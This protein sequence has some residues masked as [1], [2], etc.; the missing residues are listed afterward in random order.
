MKEVT[1]MSAW[2]TLEYLH[3]GVSHVHSGTNCQDSVR[4]YE[5]EKYIIASLADGL[6]SLQYSEIAAQTATET[7]CNVLAGLKDPF[8]EFNK[9]SEF[10]RYILDA[11]VGNV[12]KKASELNVPLQQMDCTL[13]FVCVLKKQNC[14]ILGRLGDSAICVIADQ[15]SKAINDGNKSANGTNA[16]LDSDAIDHFEIEIMDLDKENILGFIL[17]SDG[18]ENELYMKGSD[19][20]NK[21]AELY[22]NAWYNSDNPEAFIEE[23]IRKI[24]G[25]EE[26]PFDDDIS[27]AVLNRSDAKINLPEDP[28]W[29]CSCGYRNNLQTTYCLKCHRD[30]SVLY[31]NIRFRDY[32]GKAAFF[33]RINR[34]PEEEKRIVGIKE[35]PK[36]FVWQKNNPNNTRSQ[37]SNESAQLDEQ[38]SHESN[39]KNIS[40]N[41]RNESVSNQSLVKSSRPATRGYVSQTDVKLINQDE[42]NDVGAKFPSGKTPNVK[43]NSSSM[44]D[45]DQ[46]AHKKNRAN[47]ETGESNN[48]KSPKRKSGYNLKLLK[49]VGILMSITLIL[50][51]VI[52]VG[53]SKKISSAKIEKLTDTVQQYEEE[54]KNRETAKQ[55][56]PPDDFS[57]L[58]EGD[59]YWG[60]LDDS[61]IPNGFGILLHENT[62]YIGNH[63]HGKKNGK[64][65]V[66]NGYGEQNIENYMNGNLITDT[67]DD[68]YSSSNSE[69]NDYSEDKRTTEWDEENDE[70]FTPLL[71]NSQEYE[72]KY[73]ANMRQK[74]GK[75]NELIATLSI[76]TVVY[77][78]ETT[79]KIVDNSSWAHVRTEDGNEGWILTESIFN[80]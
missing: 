18:L 41:T 46:S 2:K 6:G 37:G 42:S 63:V 25:I 23:R 16:I 28:K 52:G 44:E 10:A 67:Q 4:T 39:E 29:L 45:S 69:S 17:S 7:T 72:L 40:E 57:I 49:T 43:K 62:Y 80:Q 19:H 36:E 58:E 22:F 21:T 75:E 34:D 30:F 50:G 64:F 73:V 20:V 54:L 74:P 11:V 68:S 56:L 77:L 38:A 3:K 59:Y 65:T 76:N 60:D 26:T 53:V 27:I 12:E 47:K 31:Q 9:K 35:M 33:S 66:I 55:L 78:V 70:R 15:K 1:I 79:E 48:L 32:G 61:G 51:V 8:E 71:H 24:T 14:A 13:L 5:N